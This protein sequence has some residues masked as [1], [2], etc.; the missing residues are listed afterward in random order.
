M[1]KRSILLIAFLSVS[2]YSFSQLNRSESISISSLFQIDS[3]E[4]FIFGKLI[5]KSTKAKYGASTKVFNGYTN[6][7]VY[8]S[9]TK[10]I[11][12]MFPN[13]IT[14]IFP[15]Y[16]NFYTMM[17]TYGQALKQ[18]VIQK[19]YIIFLV[20]D[21][22]LNGDGILDDDDPASIYISKSNGESLTKISSNELNVISWTFARDSN[23][24][25][26]TAQKD[27]NKDKKFINE[28]QLLYQVDLE[29]DI[30]KIKVTQVIF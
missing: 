21:A 8:N 24:I 3:S 11:L 22:D 26:F 29:N 16:D 10:K 18:S 12:S 30:S 1:K 5:D 6:A 17:Y 27:S 25:L 23:T 9:K 20:Q 15:F 4:F 14:L 28:D 7:Y 19:N 13:G 2:I